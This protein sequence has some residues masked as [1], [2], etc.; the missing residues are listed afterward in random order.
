MTTPPGCGLVTYGA[1]G[2]PTYLPL[3]SI[4]ANVH[5]VDVSARVVL[6]QLYVNDRC[7]DKSFSAQYVFPIPL[8]GAV[9]A[10]KM[11]T[12]GGQVVTGVVKERSKARNEYDIAILNNR[13]AGLLYEA[14]S[15]VFVISIGAIPRGQDVE[16]TIMYVVQLSD[17]DL[18]GYD[19][20]EF[21]L[22]THIGPRYGDEPAELA[23]PSS[24]SKGTLFNIAVEI[25]M[26]SEIESVSCQSHTIKV[27]TRNWKDSTSMYAASVK[28][29]PS[30]PASRL[31]K[32]FVLAI[33]S[34][35]LG[36]PRCVAE[37]RP[38][39][40]TI[41]M[42]LTF[43]PQFK[44]DRLP[45]QE[46]VFLVDRSGSM[47]GSQM[48]RA[49]EAL[50]I[51]LQSL[52]PQGTLFNIFSFG[53]EYSSLWPSS[54]PYTPFTLDVARRH[55]DSMSADMGGTEIK[56]GLES[57]L[58]SR[59][60]SVPMS[61]FLLTDGEVWGH[62][63]I[64]ALVDREVIRGGN[65]AAGTQLRIFTLGIGNAA[66]TALCEGVARRGNG[67]CL[68]TSQSAD[69]A[70]KVT[71][72]LM[73]STVP[74]LGSMGDIE[75]D[76]GHTFSALK[77]GNDKGK[78]TA[79]FNV[80]DDPIGDTSSRFHI[81]LPDPPKVQQVPTRIPA[82]Y[83]TNRFTV[84]V[85]LS[86]TV[87]VPK[88]VTLQ[89]KLPDGSQLTLPP[90]N[91]HEATDRDEGFPSLI[92]TLAAHRLILGLE[93]GDISSQ[94]SFDA[95]D[96]KLRDAVIEAA[97]VRFSETYQLASQ[98][99]SFIAVD[100][101][102]DDQQD[103][104]TD[105]DSSKDS[106][107]DLQD[108]RSITSHKS[109]QDGRKDTVDDGSG[110]YGSKL[111]FDDDGDDLQD[112]LGLSS[113]DALDD[114]PNDSPGDLHYGRDISMYDDSQSQ[115]V[116]IG[117]SAASVQE[118][119]DIDDS[120]SSLPTSA[121]GLTSSTASVA[122]QFKWSQSPTTIDYATRIDR[123]PETRKA[124]E[125]EQPETSPGP[126]YLLEESVKQP[127]EQHVTALCD[128]PVERA[129]F[130][131]FETFAQ[132][133]MLPS[134][135]VHVVDANAETPEAPIAVSVHVALDY[136]PPEEL[137]I[138]GAWRESEWESHQSFEPFLNAELSP[139]IALPE[140][141]PL[142][143][144]TSPRESALSPPGDETPPSPL[145]ASIQDAHQFAELSLPASG[146]TSPLY[147]STYPSVEWLPEDRPISTPPNV[148]WAP[149]VSRP[150]KKAVVSVAWTAGAPIASAARLQDFDGSFDLD[151]KLCTF[152]GKKLSPAEVKSA[153]PSTIRGTRDAEKVWATVL[154]AAYMKVHLADDKDVW[155]GL[156]QKAA[157]YVKSMLGSDFSF[158]SLIDEAS[159]FLL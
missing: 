15:D 114:E 23:A 125:L 63:D 11:Q 52:P 129:S 58:G 65:A 41:A 46:Y 91:V 87:E 66:S 75:I 118:G 98:F 32:D 2:S 1:D 22:P 69:I 88:E 137:D 37:R 154:A 111:D 138:P 92:H 90:I 86:D 149:A 153:M 134:N 71:R 113:N 54:Q 39:D 7:N 17:S 20:V 16:V 51:F 148:I 105:G 126:A 18:P 128:D 104:G 21:S 36:Q 6:T 60:R 26:T 110:A 136:F 145:S 8:S 78:V 61:L 70:Q 34:S 151:D 139:S 106:D 67:L 81:N 97:V 147:A 77:T 140:L 80:D 57:A 159:K 89:G 4:T 144:P 156:W 12:S 84:F 135:R 152:V 33:Q 25:Q 50:V 155:I 72:L 93:D 130:Q 24:S 122:H 119:I 96:E 127:A 10:F 95:T 43:V 120:E 74:P 44:L 100:E 121:T 29:D 73:A 101:G 40:R 158:S 56:S 143:M 3:I 131:S 59:K 157:D 102:R 31:G 108:G 82:L 103:G 142:S 79:S 141:M 27:D 107:D 76:W 116:A 49:K 53:S 48:M 146:Q 117:K 38:A 30:A 109:V 85:I 83:P 42:S 45:T 99:A 47:A 124:E 28:L 62:E 5:I 115:A 14:T 123:L 13:W 19:Q 132:E 133:E 55:V 64:F 112:G 9:C 68:M 150:K 35:M 94:G